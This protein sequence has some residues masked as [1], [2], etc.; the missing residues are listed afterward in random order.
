M[1][2]KLP[3]SQI[4]INKIKT[5]ITA[6][7]PNLKDGIHFHIWRHEECLYVVRYTPEALLGGTDFQKAFRQTLVE[8]G[9]DVSYAFVEADP[10]EQRSETDLEF[11]DLPF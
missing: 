3:I 1:R 7:N 2:N 5:L 10:Y 8:S 9:V 11:D 6:F 4:I